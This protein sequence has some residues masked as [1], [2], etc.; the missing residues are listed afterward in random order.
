MLYNDIKHLS[1]VPKYD[2]LQNILE[3]TDYVLKIVLCSIGPDI[4]TYCVRKI[5]LKNVIQFSKINIW[6]GT[7]K[8]I[9]KLGDNENL[10]INFVCLAAG[11][12]LLGLKKKGLTTKDEQFE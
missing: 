7:G 5:F 11:L 4:L 2:S 9:R 6:K 8:Y 10:K 1:P 3:I 12:Q